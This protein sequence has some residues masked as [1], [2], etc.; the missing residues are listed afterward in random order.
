M[1]LR[2]VYEDY[3]T[4]FEELLVRDKSVSIH[5]RNIQKVAIEM[6][7]VKH[8]LCPKFISSLFYPS[9]TH[10]RSN[11]TFLKPNVNT[12]FKGEQ[13]LRSFGPFVWDNMLP[14]NLKVLTDIEKFKC[15][16]KRWVPQ[17]CVCRLCKD[18]V[19]NLGFETLYE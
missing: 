1:A 5:H 4:S 9:N 2:L 13:S 15:E 10:T 18:Y 3:S 14:Q 12:V 8:N 6:F 11:S 19:P 17:N 7:R 16:I